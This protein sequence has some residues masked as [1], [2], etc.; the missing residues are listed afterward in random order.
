MIRNGLV[1]TVACLAVAAAAAGCAG[2]GDPPGVATAATGGAATPAGSASADTGAVA[3]YV[4]STR[5]YVRCMRDEGI[6]LPDPDARGHI[7]YSRLGGNGVLKKDPKFQAASQKCSGLRLP[8]PEELQEKLPPLSPEQVGHVRE[9]AKCM[10]AN[11]VPA[12]P[13]PDPDGHF[14]RGGIE[15][16]TEQEGKAMFRA[17]QICGPVLEGRPPT[18]PDPNATGLG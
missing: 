1:T 6:A 7:D 13:D 12:F 17:G 18:T 10:R 8:V 5:A 3:E 11:G 16:P 4:A 9:Y 2:G 15:N 14:S